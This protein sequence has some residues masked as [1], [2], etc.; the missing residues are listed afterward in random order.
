MLL[1]VDTPVL[2]KLEING[3]L[4]FDSQI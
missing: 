3:L 2:K 4:E 1:D